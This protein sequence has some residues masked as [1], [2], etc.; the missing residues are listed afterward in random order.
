MK[1]SNFQTKIDR[2]WFELKKLDTS[3]DRIEFLGGDR[4]ATSHPV[5]ATCQWPMGRKEGAV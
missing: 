5:I 3:I 4:K 1:N 2:I